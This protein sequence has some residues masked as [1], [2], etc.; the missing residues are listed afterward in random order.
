MLF[1]INYAITRVVFALAINKHTSLY[2]Q[3]Y[4]TGYINTQVNDT[5]YN[6]LKNNKRLSFG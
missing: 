2:D 1:D 4:F 5:S 3:K 6:F